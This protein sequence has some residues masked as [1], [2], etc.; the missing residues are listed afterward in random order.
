M[1]TDDGYIISKCLNGEP[2]AFGILV[3]KYKSSIFAFVYTK[4]RNFHDAQDVTQEVFIKAYRE[5]RTLKRWDSFA[6]WIYRIAYNKCKDSLLSKSRRPDRDFVEDQSQQMLEEPS[7]DSY[8]NDMTCQSLRDTLDSLPEIYREVLTLYYLGGMDSVE[9][10]NALST[11]P[12]AIRHRLSR[13]REQLK[14]EVLAMMNENFAQQRLGSSFTFRIVEAIKRI[15]IHPVSQPRGLP[16]G[17]SLA[18]GLIIAVISLNPHLV[19]DNLYNIIGGSPLPVESRV[20]KVGEIPVDVLK[21]ANIAFISNQIGKGKGGAKQPDIQN[22]F[23]MA[24]KGEGGTWAKKADMLTA[25]WGIDTSVVDGKI[26]VIGGRDSND[27]ILRIVEEYNPSTN[28]WTEKASMPIARCLLS[29]SVVNGKIYAIGGIIVGNDGLS[30]VEEYDPQTDKWTKKTDMPTARWGLDTSMVN[31]KIYAIGGAFGWAGWKD[32]TSVEEYDPSKDIWTKK[33]DMPTARWGLGTSMSNGKIYAIG[34]LSNGVSL[35]TVEEYD[36]VTD[37]WKGKTDMLT[38]RW[39]IAVSTVN[40]SIYAIG[41]CGPLSTIEEYDPFVDLWV[42]KTDMPTARARLSASEVNEKIYVIGGD[43]SNQ[44][45]IGNTVF[46]TVEEYTPE[47]WSFNVSP[48]GKIPTTW[49]QRKLD[50]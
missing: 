40:N 17:L 10:A 16:W 15:K 32:L 50:R 25:R 27:N 5:L 23:F 37:I 36:P 41:G 44:N 20:L 35:Q 6:G 4:L 48:N 29:T 31:G 12:T 33:A 26:Y 21:T 43:N 13:A 7:I 1:R 11:S 45:G 9:I 24:P 2:E 38:A 30:T 39:E 8:R 14:E 28:K 34:G 3:D 42:K 46:T 22:A 47:D 19:I 49:G 18:T